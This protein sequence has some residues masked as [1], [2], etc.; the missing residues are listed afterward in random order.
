MLTKIAIKNYKSLENVELALR[1]LNVLV[2]P[3]NSGKSNLLDCL[4]WLREFMMI[5]GPGAIESRGGFKNLVWN[6]EIQRTISIELSGSLGRKSSYQYLLEVSGGKT[7]HSISKELFKIDDA[8]LLEYP[9]SLGNYSGQYILY[10]RKQERLQNGS[11]I[12]GNEPNLKYLAGIESVPEL[13]QFRTEIENWRFHNPVPSRMRNPVQVRRD[14]RLGKEGENL[15][16]VLHSIHSE[17]RDAFQKL[18]EKLR[19]AVPEVTQLVTALTEGGETYINLKENKLNLPIPSWAMSDGT[20]ALLAMLAVFYSPEPPPL[21]CLEEPENFLHPHLL[22]LLGELLINASDRSQIMITT[23]SP[24]LLD[25]FKPENVIIIEK[26]EGKTTL[27]SAQNKK[28]IKKALQ[29]LGLG[30]FW[31][32]GALGGVPE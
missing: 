23:H 24:Y 4:E 20:L 28:G 12:R 3:N 9:V 13:S 14:L 19:S 29:D 27:Q 32:S 25:L 22:E 18:E 1:P 7:H 5:Q 8:I 6:G 2:G 30:E 17:F 31:Y 15:S 16:G 10:N 26:K 11:I 21:V